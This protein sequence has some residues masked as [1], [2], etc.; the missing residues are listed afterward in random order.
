MW[1]VDGFIKIL[2]QALGVGAKGDR[3]VKIMVIMI[4]Y[5]IKLTGMTSNH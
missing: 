5:N 2:V 4:T 3:L 1:N